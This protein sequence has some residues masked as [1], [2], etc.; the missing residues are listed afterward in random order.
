MRSTMCTLSWKIH[1]SASAMELTLRWVF[2]SSQIKQST[3]WVVSNSLHPPMQV[4]LIQWRLPLAD[5]GGRLIIS[6]CSLPNSL[7]NVERPI[8][9][10]RKVPWANPLCSADERSSD[11]TETSIR[12][13][14]PLDTIQFPYWIGNLL[15]RKDLHLDKWAV[16]VHLTW[17]GP[18]ICRP[19]VEMR[20]LYPS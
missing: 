10:E 9:A 4:H 12:I 1:N 18:F 17:C 16:Q 20:F 6:L 5:W 13:T 15:C 11:P 8:G 3:L 19:W 7:W 14:P 2:S